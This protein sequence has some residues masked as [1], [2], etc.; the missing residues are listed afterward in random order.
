MEADTSIQ[1]GRGI[2]LTKPKRLYSTSKSSETISPRKTR[3]S[4]RTSK[5]RIIFTQNED[6]FLVEEELDELD[7]ELYG[8]DAID[9]PALIGATRE[10]SLHTDHEVDEDYFPESAAQFDF[11]YFFHSNVAASSEAC[12]ESDSSLSDEDLSLLLQC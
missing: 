6:D 1:D 11:D 2:I 10:A 8:G 7:Q 4:E 9:D 5:K 3:A 12:T